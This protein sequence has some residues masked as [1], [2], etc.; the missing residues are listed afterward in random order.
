MKLE[1]KLV[2]S[3]MCKNLLGLYAQIANCPFVI[4]EI[5]G[6]LATDVYRL[7]LYFVRNAL[8]FVECV[9]FGIAK[10]VNVSVI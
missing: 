4:L 5:A 3:V 8:I 9:G 6:K 10:G 7:I 2:N 1:H